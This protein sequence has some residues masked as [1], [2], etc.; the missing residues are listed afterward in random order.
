MVDGKNNISAAISVT[1]SLWASA[2]PWQI[3]VG[4][5]EWRGT[6]ARPWIERPGLAYDNWPVGL[7]DKASA[8]GAGDSR[9]ESWAGHY[10]ALPEEGLAWTIANWFACRRTSDG[11]RPGPRGRVSFSGSCAATSWTHV[12]PTLGRADAH[13][14]AAHTRFLIDLPLARICAH[15]APPAQV[16]HGGD[17]AAGSA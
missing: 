3:S 8:P 2:W 11:A 10:D 7:M 9:F 14:I 5:P 12:R 1:T 15:W 17:S 13:A 16:N 4:P 6:K